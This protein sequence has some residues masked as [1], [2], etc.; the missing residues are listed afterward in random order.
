MIRFAVLMA[1]PTMII[2]GVL[3][4]IGYGGE[5]GPLIAAMVGCAAL[6]ALASWLA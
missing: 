6:L 4:I 1:L 2:G 3:L 5:N